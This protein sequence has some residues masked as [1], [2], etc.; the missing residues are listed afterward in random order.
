MFPRFSSDD[1][2]DLRITKTEKEIARL[3]ETV[4]K[5]MQEIAELK[6]GNIDLKREITEIKQDFTE[7][8]Q[9]LAKIQQEIGQLR[10]IFASNARSRNMIIRSYS[11]TGMVSGFM[12]E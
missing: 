5:G 3:N 1:P 8:R 2:R 6:Q 9:D 4:E 10:E 7:I 11:K 12:P